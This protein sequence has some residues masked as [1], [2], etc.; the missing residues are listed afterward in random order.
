MVG[1]LG[2]QVDGSIKNC[3]AALQHERV[4]GKQRHRSGG[5]FLEYDPRRFK[6]L[7][8]P[9]SFNKYRVER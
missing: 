2:E 4:L 8:Q 6:L 5:F 9:F 7:N 3:I 1:K